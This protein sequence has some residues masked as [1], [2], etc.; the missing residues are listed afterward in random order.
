M[1][2]NVINIIVLVVATV[3]IGL[4]FLLAHTQKEMNDMNSFLLTF[5]KFITS[6]KVF[7]REPDCS[8]R[9]ASIHTAIKDG[10]PILMI[11]LIKDN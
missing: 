11:D 2:L 7:I 3:A 8:I 4:Q 10:K 5:N 9:Q 1:I 6:N